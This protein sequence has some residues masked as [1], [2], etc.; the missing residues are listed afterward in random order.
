MDIVCVLSKKMKIAY[1]ARWNIVVAL[2]N[3]DTVIAYNHPMAC[4]GRK[5]LNTAFYHHN[6]ATYSLYI[7]R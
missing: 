7:C 6:I 3:D 2:T 1:T 5:M 4:F